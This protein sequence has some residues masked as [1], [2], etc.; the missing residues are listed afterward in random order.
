M[1]SEASL[2]NIEDSSTKNECIHNDFEF[3]Y[4]NGSSR[5]GDHQI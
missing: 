2:Q 3:S 4:K 5:E 1:M